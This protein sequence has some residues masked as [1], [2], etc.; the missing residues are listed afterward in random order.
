MSSPLF[1]LPL[2]EILNT[3][4]D[5]WYTYGKDNYRFWV[6]YYSNFLVTN[7]KHLE[8]KV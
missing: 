8:V 5:W 3:F 4:F 1:A 2:P 7:P 6:G